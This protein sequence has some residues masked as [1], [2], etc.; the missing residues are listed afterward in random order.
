MGSAVMGVTLIT[1]KL[2]CA[3]DI[4]MSNPDK[5][6]IPGF[7]K[8]GIDHNVF[9]R[10][11]LEGKTHIFIV[12]GKN[13]CP[14]CSKTKQEFNK[15]EAEENIAD[16]VLYCL[17]IKEDNLETFDGFIKFFQEKNLCCSFSSSCLSFDTNK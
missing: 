13:D 14:P 17:Y 9:K 10:E 11:E 8:F 6:E 5:I 1:E 2:S 15:L 4:N 7:E 16:D 12:V 3:E